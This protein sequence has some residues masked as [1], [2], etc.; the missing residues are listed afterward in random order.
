MSATIIPFLDGRS[1]DPETTAV[2]GL[3]YDQA[4]RGMYD[5]GQPGIVQELIAKGVIAAAQSGERD[6]DKLARL[7]LE[8]IG[9]R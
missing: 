4:C 7:A 2:M 8:T 3:A 5:K 1:F 9:I 6:P